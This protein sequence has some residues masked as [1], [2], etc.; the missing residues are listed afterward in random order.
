MNI[1][2]QL[3]RIGEGIKKAHAAGNADHVR[4]LGAEYRRLQQ[5]LQQPQPE[6][7]SGPLDA[8][9]FGFDSLGKSVGSGVEALG[10]L[11]GWQGLEEMGRAQR[12]GNEA[13]IARRRYQR[14]EHAD[15][16]FKNVREGDFG[17]ALSS[18]G[19]G[20]AEGGPS[21]APGVIAS[22]GTLAA[23]PLALATAAGATAFGTVQALGEARE[24]RREKG[25]DP[26]A[27]LGDLA[28]AIGSGLVELV[29]VGKGA[30]F[31]LSF[32]KEGLQE[33]AQEGLIVGNSAFQGGEYV[34]QEVVDRLVDSGIIG[35]TVSKGAS[36]ATNAASKVIPEDVGDYFSRTDNKEFTDDQ[37]RAAER[38]VKAAD[39]D[40]DT[41]GNVDHT[42]AGSAKGAANAALRG[43]AAE[44]EAIA[45][46]LRKLAKHQGARDAETALNA[47]L[48]TTRHQ[49][50]TTPES[51][52]SDIKLAYDT[53]QNAGITHTDVERLVSLARQ[54]NEIQSF[55][56]GDKNDMGGFSKIFSRFDL[57]DQRSTTSLGGIAVAAS[58]SVAT[59]GGMIAANRASRLID[60][61]TN[62]RSKVKRFV[63][64]ALKDGK[65]LD[66][67]DG[68]TARDTLTELKRQEAAQKALNRL[69]FERQ[70]EK[71]KEA[72]V[73]AT[74]TKGKAALDQSK[75]QASADKNAKDYR[76]N[77]LA[78]EDIFE[79]DYV[80][81][82]TDS[83]IDPYR[84]W[85][86]ATGVGPD[87]TLQ[88]LEQL[89]R[90]GVVPEGTAQRFRE[91]IRSF[92]TKSDELY[93]IQRL[94]K[95]RANP[96][97]K[98]HPK[99]AKVKPD[100]ETVLK[101]FQATDTKPTS[102]RRK[103]KAL[104]GDR[105][106][107]NV[108]GEIEASTNS[109]S[110]DQY[111]M[112]WDLAESIN[113]PDM[114]RAQ[115]FKLVESMLPMIF[116]KRS[117]KALIEFWRKK[118]TPLAAIGND[119]AIER[120][121]KNPVQ[122]EEK[123]LKEKRKAASKPRK[124]RTPKAAN[125]N[126]K[127]A[128]DRPAETKA[129]K[130][131]KKLRKPRDPDAPANVDA[132]PKRP[133]P[134]P[135]SAAEKVQKAKE[136][137]LK[138]SATKKAAHKLKDRV[139]RKVEVIYDAVELAANDEDALN[140]YIR[141]LPKSPEGRV[142]NLI[143]QFASDRVTV[144]MLT[145]AYAKIYNIPPAQAAQIV[146]NALGKME[147]K[148][149]LK[150][151]LIK[152]NARLRY[153][154]KLVT[155]EDGKPMLN[156]DLQFHN[157]NATKPDGLDPA[158]SYR[159]QVAKA[160]RKVERMVHQGDPDV[161]FSPE[162]LSDGAFNALKDIPASRVDESFWPILS[163]LNDMRQS[164]L[165][166]NPKMLK[167]IED[168]L[169]GASEKNLGPIG[170][171]LLKKDKHGRTDE[172]DI[173]S[174]AQMLFK[175]RESGSHSWR[176][177]WMAGANLRVYSLNGEAHTQGGD[178]MKGILRAP[179][180]HKV[181]GEAGLDYIYHGIGNLLGFD[182]E[183][184]ADRRNALFDYDLVDNMVKFAE[185]PFGRTRLDK[186]NGERTDIGLTVDNGE[187]FFQVLN[188]AHE[189][190]N[191]VD[192]ARARH[193]DKAKLSNA[194]LLKHPEVRADMAENY[195]TDFIVQLDASNNAYQ[196]AGMV[197]GY[198]DVLQ[199]TGMLPPEGFDGDP[200][201][202]KGADIYM[203]PALSIADRIPELEFLKDAPSKLRKLFKKPIGTYLYA[204]QF[205]SRRDAFEDVLQEIAGPKTEIFGVNEN[206]LISVPEDVIAGMTSEEG[207]RF[208][209]PKYSADGKPKNPKIKRKRIVQKGDGFA[210]QTA[211]GDRGKFGEAGKVY[212]T[213][214][215]AI[216]A[217]YA[218][219]LY[220]RMS[221]ELV[222]EMNVRYPGMRLYLGF[223]EK[224]S[225]IVKDR[226][227]ET[228]QVPTKDGMMLEY[229]FRQNPLFER[230]DVELG[231]GNVVPMGV[232]G[233]DYK[234]AGQG[235]AAFMTHQNDAWA[236][237]ET[238]KRMKESGGLLTFNPIHDSYGF[239]PADAE[240]GQKIWTEVMQ[241]LGGAEYNIF[242]DIL[243]ANQISIEEL[244]GAFK[245]PKEAEEI[246]N[247]IMGRQGVPKVDPKQI[248]TALS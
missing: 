131:L 224:V 36:V 119:Y 223:A 88:V 87:T 177:E 130:A 12:E 24:E 4:K 107:K 187:G 82:N 195:E 180:K 225:N 196:I 246:R 219:N 175:V 67:I 38:L 158:L 103:Q 146:N 236:L 169:G 221:S 160:V 181:G 220:T 207:F 210:V 145:D 152:G 140:D 174:V 167:Q 147:A 122:E 239:H 235:L 227:L 197:M 132:K 100:P 89:Q 43:I 63:E 193:K 244:M 192:W 112:L 50:S 209:T 117:Q 229:S 17:D 48:R 28:T 62:R 148:G 127:P 247:F 188:A 102:D 86:E 44:V 198:T 46:D 226:G 1:E 99:D 173:R 208:V 190:K 184:P 125:D 104:E 37:K 128:T 64:S 60:K 25:L 151:R 69:V 92:S 74:A 22:I 222:R 32:T 58:G 123:V 10:Q 45:V 139:E 179:E 133:K 70:A 242:L 2:D 8:I 191:M 157:P 53:L 31:A 218:N 201:T 165:Q 215:D 137:T 228:V 61:L 96:E 66:P 47:L 214:A 238:H 9:V 156:I 7:N 85:Q 217:A 26:E 141:K 120:E 106:Y 115:R 94:V 54:T 166:L 52:A 56:K 40:M 185:D 231:D 144:N 199:S 233:T 20:V 203:E 78:T 172:A 23:S 212:E 79:N 162:A 153:D 121:T 3:H 73:A 240:R 108:I 81:D 72:K 149:M 21:V 163:F 116:P 57:T 110:P 216:R 113:S 206:G 211:D 71:A 97:G 200:D 205:N 234:L 164:H 230:V 18:L 124:V 51:F 105:R 138:K 204:S 114:T 168:A 98:P 245:N 6:P 134:E 155:D 15:G 91:D 33:A 68:P 194:E 143:Y 241:E 19:Y 35:G 65:K 75:A 248:P 14:P 27:N 159:L 49:G 183:A 16:I 5:Q 171:V 161:L 232:Q 39:F 11:T 202:L 129:E 34:P 186:S 182:K 126:R 95:M 142:E 41:L 176:Q 80:P 109:L 90:E 42:D 13:D 135:D 189:V 83:V 237:R 170:E 178:L 150:R 136:P 101:K 243:Q 59:A 118:M 111:Q 55:T 30:G 93:S 77:S 154:G 84:K 29:P 213:E 76:L